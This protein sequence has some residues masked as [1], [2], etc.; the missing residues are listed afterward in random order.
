VCIPCYKKQLYPKELERTGEPPFPY[1][2]DIEYRYY[3]DQDNPMW[4]RDY[5]L[6]DQYNEDFAEWEDEWDRR[7]NEI[8]SLPHSS[9]CPICRAPVRRTIPQK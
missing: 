5:P 4:S 1:D 6:I 7:A 3:H 8:T 2:S 9:K